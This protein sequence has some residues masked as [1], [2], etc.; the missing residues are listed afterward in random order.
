MKNNQNNGATYAE[1]MIARNGEFILR[2]G[3]LM[4]SDIEHAASLAGVIEISRE[5]DQRP[6]VGDLVSGAYYDGTCPYKYGIVT[7]IEG[8]TVTICAH[9]YTPFAS[10]AGDRVRLSVSGGPFFSHKVEELQ[11]VAE[12]VENNF[13]FFGSAGAC[14]GGSI[15]FPAAVRSWSIPYTPKAAA[16]IRITEDKDGNK[17]AACYYGGGS[18]FIVFDGTFEHAQHLAEYLGFTW[19]ACEHDANHLKL[20]HNFRDVHFW[21]ID[22]IPE[23]AKPIRAYSNGFPRNCYAY[24]DGFTITIYRPN[25]NSAPVYIDSNFANFL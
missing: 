1:K 12:H 19:E 5:I 6:Q 2:H 22:E 17:F 3:A 11:P 18:M 10:L 4:A 13:C 15:V 24:N 9:P 20:S 23:G 16:Y 8:D 7:D 21:N 14:A 25:P